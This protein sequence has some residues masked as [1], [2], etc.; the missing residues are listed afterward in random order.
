MKTLWRWLTEYRDLPRSEQPPAHC[1]YC[2]GP[3]TALIRLTAHSF[4]CPCCKADIT[5]RQR[6]RFPRW[7]F[8]MWGQQ[9]Y[10]GWWR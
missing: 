2:L 3:G 6:F 4:A 1:P 10:E 9:G 7:M 5:N 8:W